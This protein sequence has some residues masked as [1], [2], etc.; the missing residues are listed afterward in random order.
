MRR[1]Q[2]IKAPSDRGRYRP[3]GYF[4]QA[5][6]VDEGA[7]A[8]PAVT[9]RVRGNEGKEIVAVSCSNPPVSAIV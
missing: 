6:R 8:V 5:A 2:A 7:A 1:P 9:F 4:P 3:N